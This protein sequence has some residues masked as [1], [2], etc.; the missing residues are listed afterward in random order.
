MIEDIAR[1][2]HVS[3][4]KAL[5]GATCS[6][7]WAGDRNGAPVVIKLPEPHSE[8]RD[9]GPVLLAFAE[10]GGVP[11]L[12]IDE[13]TGATLMPFLLPGHT[14]NIA[15]IDDLAAVDVCAMVAQRLQGA[16]IV[17]AWDMDRWFEELWEAPDEPLVAEAKPR[18]RRLIDTTRR[19]TLL[20][21]D[22]HHGNI[23]QHGDGWVAIDP[24]G[25]VGDP[26]FDVTGFIRNPV[27]WVP[28]L[29]SVRARIE[30]FAN[31]LGEP[32]DRIWG[33]CFVQT[34]ISALWCEPKPYAK[35]WPAL[36]HILWELRKEYE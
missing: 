31:R 3:L 26:A 7:V 30:R 22:L 35:E 13:E 6:E 27:G 5:P 24:K 29:E 15:I 25:V 10:H 1:R 20:H 32:I 17:P 28:T 23:L 34:V 21:G 14:L 8:E 33:W 16:P 19:N 9:A 2:W 36:A 4:E 11:I 12:D 18:A